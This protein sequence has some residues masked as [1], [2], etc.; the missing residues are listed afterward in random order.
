[1][2]QAQT[3]DILKTGANVFVTGEPGAGKSYVLR[4][5]I[6]YLRKHGI[7][8]AITASTGIAATHIGGMTIHSWS[9]IG[10]RQDMSAYELDALASKEYVAKRIAKTKVLIIDEISMLTPKMFS[11]VDTICRMV[12]QNPEPFGGIQ[13]V[14]VGDFFQLPP[15]QKKMAPQKSMELFAEKEVTFVYESDS[16][17]RLG[18]L[19]CYISE[20]HRQDDAVFL[21]LL[22][23][24]RRNSLEEEH[25]N[26]IQERIVPHTEIPEE[27]TK[28]FTHNSD[29]DNINQ[30]ELAKL[31]GAMKTYTMQ[32]YGNDAITATLAK[33]CL[34]PE[35]LQLKKDAV[36]LFTKNNPS[37]G[38][39]NGTQGVVIDF[40]PLGYPV[41]ETKSGKIIHLELA[42]WSI[43]HD[44]KIV[45]SIS[46]LPL[47]LAWAITVHK[48]QGMSLDRALMDLSGV[49]EYG[50]GYVALSRVRTLNGIYILGINQRALEVHPQILEVDQEFRDQSVAIAKTFAK[51]P[52]TEITKMHKNFITA[53]G[54]EWK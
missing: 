6:S 47:R 43:E 11:L 50:Q 54:G 32:S 45:G 41:V 42:E 38:Y 24:I 49:F 44:G 30:A 16:W 37:K 25:Y 1:M 21:D 15:I 31:S 19:V 22:S 2:T 34:S 26:A 40:N 33:S 10:I 36:V 4:E 8:P 46:Q 53:M 17:V 51:M 3:L 7:E 52:K 20:Q 18:M 48:S 9:G 14:C 39:A 12:R 13:V 28:L 23:A 5:Y 35:I 29:V 27:I